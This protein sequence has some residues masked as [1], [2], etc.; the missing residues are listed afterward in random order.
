MFE[1]I[2]YLMFDYALCSRS[3]SNLG[4][5]EVVLH[6][7]LEVEVREDIVLLELEKL[8]QLGIGVNLA[9]IGLVLQAV[10]RDVDVNLLADLS[11]C[12]LSSDRS[13]KELGKLVTDAG[14]L[15]EARGLAVSDIS[16]A[17]GR[18]LLGNLHLTV[19]RL[20]QR[21]EVVLHRGEKA[22]HLLKLGTE[23]SELAN[24]GGG[25][26]HC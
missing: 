2:M 21:L 6:V 8:G 17:L 10:G 9:A 25:G 26:I 11:A 22:G 15:D 19:D 3:S 4:L 12:H 1:N 23:L 24:E 16:A 7:S 13:A 14:R 20:L 18:G 5:D